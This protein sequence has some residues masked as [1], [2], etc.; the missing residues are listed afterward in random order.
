[1]DA[2]SDEM[3]PV[4]ALQA[5]AG[6][7]LQEALRLD[8]QD[9]WRVPGHIEVASG[10]AKT[11]QRRLVTVCPALAAWLAPY[12][13]R[14]GPLCDDSI[15]AFAVR[16]GKL[17]QELGIASRKNGLRHGF[18]THHLALHANEGLTA[19]QAG[20]TPAII[21]AHYRGLATPDEARAWFSVLP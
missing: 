3:R 12:R 10:K 14:T 21:H 5:L 4:I 7:R 15:A 1:L 2:A 13:D 19:A 18:V 16:F 9:V 8:W 20:N 11:R 17:R 6:L